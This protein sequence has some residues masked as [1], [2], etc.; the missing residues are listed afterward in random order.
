MQQRVGHAG[1]E[2]VDVPHVLA[3]ALADGNGVDLHHVTTAVSVSSVLASDK[4]L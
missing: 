4:A 3:G 2:R 1:R